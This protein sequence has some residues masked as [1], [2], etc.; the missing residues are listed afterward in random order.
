MAIQPLQIPQAQAWSAGADFTPLAQL[1]QVYQQAQQND[2]RRQTLAGLAQNNGQIDVRPLLASGDM[3]LAQLGINIMNNQTS[4]ARDARD[5][6][7]RQ[8]EAQRTQSNADRTYQ[9]SADKTPT[10]FQ[11]DASGALTPIPGGPADPEY[12]RLVGDRQNAPAGYRWVDPANPNAGMVA[13]PGGPGE[14]VDAEVAAR[15]GLAQSFLGQLPDIKKRVAAGE[16]TGPIDAAR[17]Y[18]GIGGPG[19]I[20]RQIDSGAEALLRMLTGAG[21]NNQEA[22][23]YIRRYQFSPTDTAETLISKL[24]Q[25]EREL[26]S[27]GETVG[28]GR[29]GWTPPGTAQPQA[30]P[31]A[32]QAS[33]PQGGQP[34]RIMSPQQYN[35]LPSG[36][37]YIAPDGSQR[38]KR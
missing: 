7:F 6:A 8:Q 2:L 18:A 28:R 1:G 5:F 26:N 3:S 10:G 36:A 16:I 29:G 23:Q 20:R 15:L 38:T 14:K 22:S 34:P 11:R 24:N 21:M 19:E 37:T 31:Q 12:K 35:A 13:I 9:L 17:A 33:A 30:A 4:Q 25:L 32:P 27:V